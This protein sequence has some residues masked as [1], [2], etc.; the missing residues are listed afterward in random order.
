MEMRNGRLRSYSSCGRAT[1]S[2][3]LE[4]FLQVFMNCCSHPFREVIRILPIPYLT[5]VSEFLSCSCGAVPSLT[6]T[7]GLGDRAF[8]GLVLACGRP[9]GGPVR[10]IICSRWS[11]KFTERIFQKKSLLKIKVGS[12]LGPE[13]LAPK[14][15]LLTLTRHRRSRAHATANRVALP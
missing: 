9:V 2:V 1:K 3:F 14:H 8:A 12:P 10:G 15:A 7:S 13:E 4:F 5:T 11:M 6:L